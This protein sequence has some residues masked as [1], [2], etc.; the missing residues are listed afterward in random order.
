V[1]YHVMARPGRYPR[2]DDSTPGQQRVWLAYIRVQLR[3]LVTCGLS[4]A[5][6]RATE[7][8]VTDRGRYALENLRR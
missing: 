4:A 8:T 2:A 5:D 7:L 1:I 3:G 6:R